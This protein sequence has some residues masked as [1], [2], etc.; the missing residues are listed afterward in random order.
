MENYW[1][2]HVT[3]SHNQWAL[4]YSSKKKTN[5]NWQQKALEWPRCNF[6]GVNQKELLHWPQQ[7]P[8][9]NWTLQWHKQVHCQVHKYNLWSSQLAC[10]SYLLC[11]PY[12]NRADCHALIFQTTN[13][14]HKHAWKEQNEFG[15]QKNSIYLHLRRTCPMLIHK[16]MQDCSK[17]VYIKTKMFIW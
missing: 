7:L 3:I 14:F 8:Q 5:E 4:Q 13:M 16:I 11:N 15:Q 10:M 12:R 2:N 6:V 9:S 17:H 1:I